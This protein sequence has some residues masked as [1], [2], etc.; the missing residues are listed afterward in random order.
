MTSQSLSH[1]HPLR[2]FVILVTSLEYGTIYTYHHFKVP[3]KGDVERSIIFQALGDMDRR[4]KQG[5]E[6]STSDKHSCPRRTICPQSQNDVLGGRARSLPV[7]G[8][9]R[10][11]LF[12]AM[13]S[14][15]QRRA[16]H[17]SQK[18]LKIERDQDTDMKWPLSQL[19]CLGLQLKKVMAVARQKKEKKY[20][21]TQELPTFAERGQATLDKL[22]EI[23]LGSDEESRL[24]HQ[25][26]NV[27]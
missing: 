25:Q 1:S 3:K 2:G 18:C 8:H 19:R 7:N 6:D 5:S 23:N 14:L 17:S 9:G 15:E 12:K 21:P 4:D 13:L 11:R 26:E 20:E 10:I 27:P 24:I 22:L 16:L